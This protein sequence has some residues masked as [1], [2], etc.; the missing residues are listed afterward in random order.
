MTAHVHRLDNVTELTP[1]TTPRTL[2][3]RG[4]AITA[5]GLKK[6]FG[7]NRVLRG[8][9]FHVHAGQF[10]AIVGRSGCGKSTLLRL[11]FEP[12]SADRRTILVRRPPGRQAG[13]KRRARDVPGAAAA[14]LGL[15]AVQRRGRPRR[16]A[17]CRGRPRACARNTEQCRA[18]KSPRRVAVRALRRTKAARRLGARVGQPARACLPST[19]RSARWTR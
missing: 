18:R 16:Q 12:R 9:D 4:L 5:Q 3:A 10:V 14:A 2:P 6:S 19:N 8:L 1:R 15:G 13:Q 7:D 11:L 17:R